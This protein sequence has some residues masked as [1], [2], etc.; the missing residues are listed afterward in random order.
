MV[1][2]GRWLW[3]RVGF[4]WL[5]GLCPA[6][7]G[8]A[9]LTLAL[10]DLPA[11]G[12]AL[13]AEAKGYFAAEGLALEMVH[14]VNGRRCLQHLT[15]GQ[16]QL[17]TVADTP[18][19]LAAHAGKAFD[20][21]ATIGS[22]SR[23]NTLVVRSDRGIRTAEDLKGRRIGY[24]KGTSGHYFTDTLLLFHGLD[25]SNVTMVPLD[26]ST[27]GAKLVAGEVDAAGLYV[28]YGP[29]ALAALGSRAAL[30]GGPK[31]YTVTF[32]L[33]C[34]PQVSDADLVKLL[35][36]PQRAV[37]FIAAQP[38]Q[39]NALVA[40]R[41]KLDPLQSTQLLQIYDFRMNLSQLLL[42]T[43]EAESRWAQ[44]DGMVPAAALPDYLSRIRVGPL[45]ALD[46]R[47]V[48]VIK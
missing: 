3:R 43:L 11:F 23:E 39:A 42:T 35:K 25:A 45:R 10:A 27:S 7:V 20:I 22:S 41:L 24:V 31:L 38:S 47:A 28:P 4:W 37:D 32:N 9:G 46:R 8:A 34:Q 18:I 5:L 6:G 1:E 17:A 33:V 13:I 21:V 19:M 15:D 36:A 29:Q 48:S 44:R 40:E 30:L 2:V 12:P 16:A 14:C 26:A